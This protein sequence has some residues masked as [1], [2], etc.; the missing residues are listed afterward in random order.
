MM[1]KKI[2][3]YAQRDDVEL[4]SGLRILRFYLTY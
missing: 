2:P 4:N 1:P 3:N